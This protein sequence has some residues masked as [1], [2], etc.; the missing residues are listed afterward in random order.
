MSKDV[1]LRHKKKR[2][3]IGY[4]DNKKIFSKKDLLKIMKNK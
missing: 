2:S 4:F 1:N 3:F